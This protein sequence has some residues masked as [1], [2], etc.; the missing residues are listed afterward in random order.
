MESLTNYVVRAG[1]EDGDEIDA[2][3]SQVWP[4]LLETKPEGMN[5]W[6]WPKPLKQIGGA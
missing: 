2:M 5:L 4:S 6:L 3:L 1:M